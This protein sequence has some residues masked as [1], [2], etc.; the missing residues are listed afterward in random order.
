MKFRKQFSTIMA[1]FVLAAF[2]PLTAQ[3]AEAPLPEIIANF[4][5]EILIL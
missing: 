5:Q 1:A 2:L 4:C 3:A